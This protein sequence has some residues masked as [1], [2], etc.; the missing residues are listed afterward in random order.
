MIQRQK[1][2]ALKRTF[3]VAIVLLLPMS[4]LIYQ[5]LHRSQNHRDWVDYYIK[6]FYFNLSTGEG[7]GFNDLR[8]QTSLIAIIPKSNKEEFEKLML[9]IETWA[10]R[11]LN[12]G[13]NL[14]HSV[15][16]YVMSEGPIDSSQ[17]WKKIIYNPGLPFEVEVKPFLRD[18]ETINEFK[19]L[20]V[21]PNLIV[22]SEYT[23][24]QR[25]QWTA[26]KKLWSKLIFNNQLD[27]Y[28]S[29]R[30]FFGPKKETLK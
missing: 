25:Q 6:P 26:V 8:S 29:K 15:N 2:E 23:E 24:G 17:M 27:Q 3:L 28:L 30:T 21:D 14:K 22:R 11:E 20:Y 1:K 16:L 4:Y 12:Y 9:K 7:F 5:H 19:V 18:N 10:V 13:K